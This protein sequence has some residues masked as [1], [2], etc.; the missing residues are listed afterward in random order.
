MCRWIYTFQLSA[1]SIVD[2]LSFF[3]SSFDF[4]GFFL[5]SHTCVL[6]DGVS[7]SLYDSANEL[8]KWL[9]LICDFCQS[10]TFFYVCIFV[11]VCVSEWFDAVHIVCYSNW[12]FSWQF[13]SPIYSAFTL[14]ITPLSLIPISLPPVCFSIIRHGLSFPISLSTFIAMVLRFEYTTN[15]L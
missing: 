4:F 7:T 11:C 3:S 5:F 10:L 12:L 6:C 14:A 2:D 9:Y 13:Q 15:E 1:R 8:F